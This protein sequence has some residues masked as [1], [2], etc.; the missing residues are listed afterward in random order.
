MICTSSGRYHFGFGD[1]GEKPIK[2]LLKKYAE[3]NKKKLADKRFPY[4]EGL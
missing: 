2:P 3:L 4:L 1:S